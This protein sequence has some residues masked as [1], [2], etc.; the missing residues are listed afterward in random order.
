[1]EL[2]MN[3]PESA[4]FYNAQHRTQRRVGI[5]LDMLKLVRLEFVK[6]QRGYLKRNQKG[7]IPNLIS[8][9]FRMILAIK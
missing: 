6:V 5:P 9:C 7:W 4:A 2:L 3:N 8:T 1:M